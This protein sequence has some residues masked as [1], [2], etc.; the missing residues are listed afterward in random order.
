MADSKRANGKN[1]V[2]GTHGLRRFALGKNFHEAAA[3]KAKNLI[4]EAEWH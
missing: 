2:T 4:F 3:K 1:S